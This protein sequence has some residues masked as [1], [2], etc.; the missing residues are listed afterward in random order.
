MIDVWS[1]YIF[2]NFAT[3]I[4]KYTNYYKWG[5]IRWAKHSQFQPYKVFHGNIIAIPWP[6]VFII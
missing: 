6:V 1:I 3:S 5:S 2:Y 4:N